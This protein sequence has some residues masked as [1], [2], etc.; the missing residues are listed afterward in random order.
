MLEGKT[1]WINKQANLDYK[2]KIKDNSKHNYRG[3]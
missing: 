1:G 3:Y 2:D